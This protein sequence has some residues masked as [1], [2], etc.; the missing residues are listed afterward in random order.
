MNALQSCFTTG[1]FRV[2]VATPAITLR[3]WKRRDA[4]SLMGTSKRPCVVA[5]QL[6]A[7]RRISVWIYS[8]ATQCSCTL[9]EGWI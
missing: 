8:I 5:D 2:L 4:R 9:K 6:R 1:Y 3:P 7:R